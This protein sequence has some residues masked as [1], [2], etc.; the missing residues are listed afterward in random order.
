MR[1]DKKDQPPETPDHD[2]LD[3][4]MDLDDLELDDLDLLDAELDDLD[5]DTLDEDLIDDD[6]LGEDLEISESIEN[7]ADLLDTDLDTDTIATAPEKRTSFLSKHFNI[8]VI[9]AAILG[10]GAIILSTLMS[11]EKPSV[12]QSV[13]APL[14]TPL[15]SASTDIPT[16]DVLYPVEEDIAIAPPEGLL[17]MPGEESAPQPALTPLPV[18]GEDNALPQFEDIEAPVDLATVNAEI[19]ASNIEVELEEPTLEPE[20]PLAAEPETAMISIPT[21]APAPVPVQEKIVEVEVQDPALVQELQAAQG[22]IAT[23][24]T[25]ETQLNTQLDHSKEQISSLQNDLRDLQK[26]LESAQKELSTQTAAA[27][28]AEREAQT[29]KTQADEAAR[30]ARLA[31][32]KAAAAKQAA[33][34]ASVTKPAIKK[35]TPKP[36]KSVAVKPVKVE[37]ATAQTLLK[38]WVMKSAQPGRAVI[39][40]KTT[41]AYL[42]VNTG[43][44]LKGLGSVSAIS[45][46][47]GIWVIQ[48]SQGK[49]TQ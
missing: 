23:L 37:P 32:Q 45:V 29:A 8:V 47:N 39:Q 7:T 22:R 33:K 46:Q 20:V 28:R 40:N 25:K 36:V 4:D 26:Q 49:I 14:S 12:L 35:E 18:F 13:P 41:G 2:D 24:E 42:T 19:A 21:P 3:L 1:D 30:K 48:G 38:D 27:K 15:E 44:Q 10:G 5:L 17:S 11:S 6:L 43:D 31:E 9:V 34:Q 16:P